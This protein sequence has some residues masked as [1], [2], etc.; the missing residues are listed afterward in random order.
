VL[1]ESLEGSDGAIQLVLL[2]FVFEEE[3]VA[4]VLGPAIPASLFVFGVGQSEVDPVDES[5]QWCLAVETF[6]LPVGAAEDVVGVSR[7]G[8]VVGESWEG[9][10][11]EAVGA[12]SGVAVLG[13]VS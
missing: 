1:P 10:E 11:F 8:G 6:F 3:A 5:P 4:N 2:I 12:P 9:V 13:E 7:V